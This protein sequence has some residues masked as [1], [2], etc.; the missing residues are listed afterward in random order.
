VFS[1]FKLH[2]ASYGVLFS[3]LS[4]GFS[5]SQ[6]TD[7]FS[8]IQV[9]NWFSTKSVF[10][11]SY[12]WSSFFHPGTRSLSFSL[13]IFLALSEVWSVSM[14]DRWYDLKPHGQTQIIEVQLCDVCQDWRGRLPVV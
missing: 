1:V 13:S 3:K 12:F 9:T 8:H 7:H 10:T 11:E 5:Q 4:V 6:V 14:C 2:D